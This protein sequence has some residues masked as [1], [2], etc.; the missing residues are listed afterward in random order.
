MVIIAADFCAAQKFP[1]SG[2][3]PVPK[4]T[5]AGPRSL[6]FG[7]ADH[8]VAVLTL[9]PLVV[10]LHLDVIRRFRLQVIYQVPLLCTCEGT[11]SKLT[12]VQLPTGARIMDECIAGTF[13]TKF[14]GTAACLASTKIFSNS[15]WT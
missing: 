2:S 10:A 9:P 6:T 11:K 3:F 13:C 5:S 15:L 4:A 7:L 1:P 12:A 14:R 8:H